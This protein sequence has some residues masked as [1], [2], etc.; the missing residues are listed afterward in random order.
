MTISYN[1]MLAVMKNFF[2][3]L[4]LALLPGAVGITAEK[5]LPVNLQIIDYDE[6]INAILLSGEF[7]NVLDQPLR[8]WRGELRLNNST[9]HEVISLFYEYQAKRSIDPGAGGVWS[10]WL[11]YDPTIKEHVALRTM[12]VDQVKAEIKLIRVLFED[13]SQQAF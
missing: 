2:I 3:L 11:K 7:T 9:T 5:L 10:F 4:I 1:D 12:R 8:A 6:K 13:G